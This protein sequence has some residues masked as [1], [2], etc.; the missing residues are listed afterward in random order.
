VVDARPVA[1]R[2][3]VGGSEH[4]L[5][6]EDDAAVRSVTERGLRARGYKVTAVYSSEDALELG[7]A[8]ASVDILLTDV[9]LPGISGLDLAAQLREKF[10]TLPVLTMSGHVEDPRQQAALTAGKYAFLPKPFS[11]PGLLLRL[12]EVLSAAPRP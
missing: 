1:V 12:R 5:L 7:D 2:E 9:R 8:L 6:V 10:P 4:I 11:L 3:M